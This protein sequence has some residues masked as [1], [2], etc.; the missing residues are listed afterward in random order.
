VKKWV[1]YMIVQTQSN[2][3]L[4]VD[5]KRAAGTGSFGKVGVH[6][7]AIGHN[8]QANNNAA[9]GKREW[10]G[11]FDE[12]RVMTGGKDV[13]WALLDFQSQRE[14]STFLKFGETVTK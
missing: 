6:G 3:T 8:Y 4:F 12:V 13:N 2:L 7:F 11:M 5:G 1:H 10:D 9:T 14:G